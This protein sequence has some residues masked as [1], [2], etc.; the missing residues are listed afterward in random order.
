MLLAK[1]R[2]RDGGSSM[3]SE[4]S[5]PLGVYGA[6]LTQ[7]RAR[8]VKEAHCLAAHPNGCTNEGTSPLPP[9]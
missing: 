4:G 5:Q 9:L 2:E 3:I 8:H 6:E 1:S 7:T